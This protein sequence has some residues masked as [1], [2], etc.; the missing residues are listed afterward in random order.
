[1]AMQAQLNR[2]TSKK[3]TDTKGKAKTENKAKTDKPREKVADPDWLTNNVKPD[4]PN[5]T[6]MHKGSPWH[7]CGPETGGKCGGKWRKHNPSECKGISKRENEAMND[8]NPKK[9]KLMQALQTVENNANEEDSLDD[10]ENV[11]PF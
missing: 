5:K 8:S 11:L 9:L 3:T 10:D 4:P 7:W 6:M 1:M 2:F